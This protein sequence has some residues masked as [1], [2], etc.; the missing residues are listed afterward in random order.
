MRR[1]GRGVR[2]GRRKPRSSAAHPLIEGLRQ[3][4]CAGTR[5]AGDE[6]S[7]VGLDQNGDSVRTIVLVSDAERLRQ[8]S[9]WIVVG[10][11]GTVG[12]TK[13]Q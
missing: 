11:L 12:S 5:Q 4:S 6:T 10:T 3:G 7:G 13:I 8:I 1:G 2:G 9:E